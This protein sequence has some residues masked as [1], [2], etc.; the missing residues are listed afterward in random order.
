MAH[1]SLFY[2]IYSLGLSSRGVGRGA[3]FMGEGEEVDEVHDNV[4]FCPTCEQ[5]IGHIILRTKERGKGLDHLVQC[6]VCNG[7]HTIELRPTKATDVRFTLSEGGDSR[8]MVI[9]VDIDEQFTI[10]EEF[11]YDD[12]VWEITRLEMPNATS[13]KQASANGVKMVWATRRD[14]IMVRLTFTDGE[15]SFSDRIICEPNQQFKCGSIFVH[16]GERWRIRALHSGRG[17]TLHG[18]MK[19][20]TIRRI[21]LHLPPNIEEAKEKRIRERGRWR[22]QEFQGREDHQQKVREANIRRQYRKKEE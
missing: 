2:L 22:G 15:Y 1:L 20:Q 19:A 11:E 14:L 3:C 5:E 16:N 10:G 18:S 17:R 9:E 6:A 12:A 7:I 13:S 21:F 8:Q 4:A